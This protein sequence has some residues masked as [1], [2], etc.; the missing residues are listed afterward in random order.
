MRTFFTIGLLHTLACRTD[1]SITIQNPA[2]KADIFSHSDG[3]VVLEGFATTF[4]GTVTDA[5]HTPP[6]HNHL[7]FGWRLS[8][9][10]SFP[11]KMVRRCDITLDTDNSEITLAVLDA[12][13]ARGNG[14]FSFGRADKHRCTDRHTYC[15]W[16]V[17]F[18]PT[19]HL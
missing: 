7:V 16:C 1:K 6:T 14:Y 18:G 15:G 13:N 4:V 5:N 11:M 8:V 19:H 2:P 3:D 12:E 10:I 17:L 9:M